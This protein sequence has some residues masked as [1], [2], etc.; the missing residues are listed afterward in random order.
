M[1]KYERRSQFLRNWSWDLRWVCRTIDNKYYT[2]N[3][4]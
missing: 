4:F 1:S 3:N 2:H